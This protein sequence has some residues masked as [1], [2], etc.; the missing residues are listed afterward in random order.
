VADE[1]SA[2]EL[3]RSIDRLAGEIAR[4]HNALDRLVRVDVYEAHRAAD[5]ADTK[6]NEARI[7]A[8]EKRDDERDK[9]RE[10]DRGQL[11]RVLVGAILGCIGSVASSV[12]IQV[13]LR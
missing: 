10:V 4:M 11:R 6:R 3:G 2:G 9:Q 13:L 1:P 8:L 7:D 12:V 5:V